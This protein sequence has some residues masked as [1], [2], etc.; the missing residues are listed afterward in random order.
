MFACT[1]S[2]EVLKAMTYHWGVIP[3]FVE[4]IR[5]IAGY[6]NVAL[7]IARR[8]NLPK[9]SKVIITSGMGGTIGG[10]NTIRVIEV[11]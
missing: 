7:E 8:R 10:T 9:G 4:N 1:E 3:M 11:L 5:N 2:D 6:D